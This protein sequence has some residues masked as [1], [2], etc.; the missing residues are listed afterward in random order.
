MVVLRD[1]RSAEYSAY[2]EYFIDDYSKEIS[3]NYGHAMDVAIDL[4]EK[5]LNRSFPNGLESG[6]HDLLCIE[7]EINHE[8]IVVG[9]LWHSKN[10]S[11]HSTF[12]YDFYV[13]NDYRGNGFGKQAISELEAQVLVDGITQIKLRV[14]YHNKRAFK[15]YQE[16]GFIITGYNMSKKISAA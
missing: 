7:A 16:T 12:I 14:A 3:E 10:S 9:Y 13:A 4:A 1:M 6:D 8:L 11:E 5:E 15:L 2:C